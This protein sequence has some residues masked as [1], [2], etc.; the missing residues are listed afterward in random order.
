MGS[1]E[2][3]DKTTDSIGLKDI[4]FKL[5]EKCKLVIDLLYFKGFTQI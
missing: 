4:I 5:G 3:L 1:S 2:N